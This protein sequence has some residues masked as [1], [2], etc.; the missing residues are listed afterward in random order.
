[1]MNQV[2]DPV[3]ATSGSKP[4]MRG[5]MRIGFVPGLAWPPVGTAWLRSLDRRLEE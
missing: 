2:H 1:M 4:R 5:E 3:N